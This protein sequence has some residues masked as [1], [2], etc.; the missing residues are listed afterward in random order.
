[1]LQRHI[2]YDVLPQERLG[3]ADLS[4]YK[5]VVLPDLGPVDIDGYVEAGGAVVATG[6]T[7]LGVLPVRRLA[8]YDTEES[9]RSLH[10]EGGI[11]VFGD[12]HVVE[13]SADVGLRALSRAPY[14]PPEKCHGHVQLDHPGVV[15]SGGVVLLPWTVG[16]A[17]R[18]VG[19]TVHRDLFID[20]VIGVGAPEVETE[21]PEQVE[22]VV[23]RSAA[24]I[25]VHLL[26]RSGDGDQRFAP[27]VPI[28]PARLKVPD[29]VREVRA[30]RSGEQLPVTDGWVGLSG[31]GL[32][33]VLA[34]V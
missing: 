6:N 2:P 33:E 34:C 19:L 18:E 10:L 32:F 27:P 31:I 11:P 23:G 28:G 20:E 30:L 13:T 15:R 21:L 14:G 24:G 4:R 17:Y 3:D 9:T 12:F 26:N 16:R 8:I 25:V 22:I 29:G 1:L 5:V 7:E